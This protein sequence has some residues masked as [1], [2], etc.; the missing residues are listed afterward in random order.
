MYILQEFRTRIVVICVLSHFI[1]CVTFYTHSIIRLMML[2]THF[3][4][5]FWKMMNVINWNKKGQW[6]FSAFYKECAFSLDIAQN[7]WI[8]FN[9]AHVVV[10]VYSAPI[11]LNSNFQCRTGHDISRTTLTRPE[12]M[13]NS[14]DLL[15]RREHN[16][17]PST[18]PSKM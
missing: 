15:N 5:F 10:S 11:L 8:E 2:R 1:P 12:L 7:E 3:R 9:R 13:L 14:T 6:D 18:F 16:I 4:V 17:P